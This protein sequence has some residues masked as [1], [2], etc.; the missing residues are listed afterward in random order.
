MYAVNF[1]TKKINKMKKINLTFFYSR[2]LQLYY[3]ECTNKISQ[4]R[5]FQNFKKYRI[6]QSK[7]VPTFVKIVLFPIKYTNIGQYNV[8]TYIPIENYLILLNNIFLEKH[9]LQDALNQF[10]SKT[11]TL[12]TLPTRHYGIKI[13]GLRDFIGT[14]Y[15]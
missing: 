5:Y 7:Q 14:P 13:S 6:S 10:K 11:E 12:S 3:I 2:Q 15:I 9:F 8:W 4:A 1:C